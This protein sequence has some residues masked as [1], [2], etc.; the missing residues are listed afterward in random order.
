MNDIATNFLQTYAAGGEP[1]EGWMYAKAL[2]QAD[3]DYS[4]ESLQR[5]DT[6]LAQI[7]ERTKPTR[8]ALDSPR[9]RNFASLVV[10]Y[11]VEIVRRRTGADIAWHDRASALRVLPP[12]TPLPDT[13]ATRLVANAL[14]QGALFHPLGWLEAQV[15]PVG[16]RV[17]VA[18]YVASLVTQLERDGPAEW[19]N[20]ARG[21]G[22]IASWQM[23]LAAAGRPVWPTKV[24][25][26]DPTTLLAL[27]AES[28]PKSVEYG[29]GELATNP[30]R[31][32]WRVFSYA[33]YTEQAG[34]RLDAVIVLAAS[35]GARAMRMEVAFPFRPAREGQRLAILRPALREAN[36]TVET[37]GKLNGAL[38]R[39]IRDVP[40]D[41]GT[42]W[43]ELYRG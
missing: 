9:G 42:S 2:Q 21:V 16:K 18:D 15:L 3:L 23:M 33:G 8:E 34:E 4:L 1:D 22:R 20:A 5:L 29:Y 39:G 28:I 37:V 35:Y 12:G 19:W 38:E 10:F 11:V 43:D 13:S 25:Q 36:L 17:G 14:D 41:I 40:W 31:A 24:T 7:R 27:Q 30:E 26:A 6:L 32:L